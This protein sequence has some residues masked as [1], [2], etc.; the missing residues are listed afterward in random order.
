MVGD[1]RKITTRIIQIKKMWQFTLHYN[2]I[3]FPHC[4]K[5][6]KI[7]G[8]QNFWI[9]RDHQPRPAFSSSRACFVSGNGLAEAG[10]WGYGA[11]VSHEETHGQKW[12]RR[13]TIHQHPTRG[14]HFH[15]NWFQF[16]S[17]S[18]FKKQLGYGSNHWVA[19]GYLIPKWPEKLEITRKSQN[20][21]VQS[22]LPSGKLT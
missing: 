2:S 16:I 4:S 11:R 14:R 7:T 3:Q 20:L 13:S 18:C 12:G 17:Q 5:Q 1:S 8:Q 21:R 22:C 19:Q 6:I 9:S 15:H 10:L